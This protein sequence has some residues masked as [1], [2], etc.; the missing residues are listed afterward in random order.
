MDIANQIVVCW[1]LFASF[2][3]FFS[4]EI[5]NLKKAA[6]NL[7]LPS[8]YFNLP[9]KDFSKCI[10]SSSRILILVLGIRVSLPQNASKFLQM[11]MMHHS[12]PTTYWFVLYH[13]VFFATS[14][15]FVHNMFAKVC[16]T[17]V[18][19]QRIC[20]NTAVN[21]RAQKGNAH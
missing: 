1:I 9:Q 20:M 7:K 10:T 8:I 3:M 4:N 2:S 6:I 16:F 15:H 18:R 11:S 13:V 5:N 12:F 14:S 21:C 19:F 17:E